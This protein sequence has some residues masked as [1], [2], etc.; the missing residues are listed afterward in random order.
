MDGPVSASGYHSPSRISSRSARTPSLSSPAG[1]RFWLI[2]IRDLAPAGSS[3]WTHA[4]D[5]S[6]ETI[7]VATESDPTCEFMPASVALGRITRA[8]PLAARSAALP[9]RLALLRERARPF[10]G[11]LRS[12]HL[13]GLGVGQ[14]ERDVERMPHPGQGGLLAGADRQRRAL[15][16]LVRP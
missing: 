13:L 3:A 16:D 10:D 9:V 2:S 12:P 4:N 15:Q 6:E 7:T 8:G 1:E 14:L 11:V 5:R